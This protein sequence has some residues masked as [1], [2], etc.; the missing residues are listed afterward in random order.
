MLDQ[1]LRSRLNDLAPRSTG[2]PG[3]WELIGRRTHEKRRMRRVALAV[4]SLIALAVVGFGGFQLYQA[5][6]PHDLVVITD[7]PIAE[8]SGPTE[9]RTSSTEPGTTNPPSVPGATLDEADVEAARRVQ[10]QFFQSLERGDA[11]K[12]RSVLVPERAS[13]ADALCQQAKQ[14]LASSG[15]RAFWTPLIHP[16][17]WTGQGYAW[18]EQ[19]RPPVPADLDQWIK[20]EPQHRLGLQIFTGDNVLWWL[21]ME[22][23]ASGDW[24]VWPGSRDEEYGSDHTLAGLMQLELD[25]TPRPGVR[26]Q[27]RLNQLPDS[28]AVT[29]ELVIENQSDSEFTFSASDFGLTV[30]GVTPEAFIPPHS[31]LSSRVEP[32]QTERPGGWGWMLSQPTSKTTRLSYTPS[33]PKSE[34]RTW[35]LEASG[36]GITEGVEVSGSA[37]TQFSPMPGSTAP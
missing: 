14:W 35:T 19:L 25:A 33:D 3:E 9:T 21:G 27:F 36:S 37:S 22:R 17:V 28:N 6:G 10:S 29:A 15:P 12:V 5:L 7:K 31:D 24:L 11:E 26:V 32:G 20:Q 23:S 8:V 34:K 4:T 13:E 18:D 30:D 16:I 1:E 2:V